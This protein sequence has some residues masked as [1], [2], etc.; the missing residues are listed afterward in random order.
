[1]GLGHDPSQDG[2]RPPGASRITDPKPTPCARWPGCGCTLL[3]GVLAEC[4]QDGGG[5]PRPQKKADDR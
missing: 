5:E 3:A 2:R 4:F 1:M